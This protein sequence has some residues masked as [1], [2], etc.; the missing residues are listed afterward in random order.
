MNDV[1]T[2][3]FN[4]KL[5]YDLLQILQKRFEPDAMVEIRYKGL[6]IVFKTDH[7]GNPI[8]L[9]VGHKLPTGKIK[10][11]RFVRTFLKD[12]AGIVVKDHWDLKGKTW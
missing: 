1:H 8:S 6:D 9:F 10:G 2:I 7:D 12:T 4:M 11:E 5:S 3:L